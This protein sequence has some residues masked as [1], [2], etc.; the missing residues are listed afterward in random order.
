MKETERLG[1]SEVRNSMKKKKRRRAENDLRN[2]REGERG[3]DERRRPTNN[4]KEKIPTPIQTLQCVRQ[5]RSGEGGGG[6]CEVEERRT[7]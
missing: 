3:L 7:V 2:E 4:E 1:E 6:D 5:D